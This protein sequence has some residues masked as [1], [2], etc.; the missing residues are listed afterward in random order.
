MSPQLKTAVGPISDKPVT[1]R[2]EQLRLL[3][4]LADTGS[5][6][7]AALRLSVTQPALTK[8]LRLLE[9]EFGAALVHR[10][11]KGVRFTPAGELVLRRAAAVVREIER[12]RDE[13]AFLQREAGARVAV[14]LSPAAAVVLM[15]GALARLRSRWPQVA[16]SLI[17][18]VYPRALAMVRSGEIELAIGPLP[19]EGAGRDLQVQPLFD[20]Q[21]LLVARRSHPLARARSL[22]ELSQ[23]QWVVAGP[24]GGPGDPARLG[25]EAQGLPVPPVVLACE[26]FSTLVALMPSLDV[27]GIMP[28]GFY[29]QQGVHFDLV[30]L[31]LTDVLPRVTLHAVWRADVPLTV[32][33]RH[34]LDML[35]QQAA[36][37]RRERAGVAAAAT[38][39]RSGSP[40]RP[41]AGSTIRSPRG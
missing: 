30:V 7:M 14:G 29:E 18:A 38:S 21:Q 35:E 9:D 6:R 13:V 24:R 36:Q 12:A 34:L 19:G 2:L 23:A 4:A 37:I 33:A 22:A 11:P 41:R 39:G 28:A 32:P 20:A 31:P 27:V 26:S 40:P 25:F 8:A 10:S 1:M 3:L 17:D 15:P 5:L 16:V